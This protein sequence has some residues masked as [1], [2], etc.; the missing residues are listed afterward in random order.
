M[1]TEQLIEAARAQLSS[2]AHRRQEDAMAYAQIA[3]AQALLELRQ[4]LENG[5]LV[6]VDPTLVPRE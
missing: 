2:E 5:V 1:T 4:V 3:I 6:G